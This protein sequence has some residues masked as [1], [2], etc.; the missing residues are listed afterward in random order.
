MK[1]RFAAL[2]AA[3]CAL[4]ISA[5]AQQAP[6][7]LTPGHL[8][9]DVIPSQYTITVTPDAQNL[10][11]AGAVAI[12][13]HVARPTRE[14]VL[15]ALDL[16]FDHANVDGS[17]AQQIIFDAQMQT[18]HLSFARPVAPGDHVINIAY[19][20]RI[21]RASQ[22][23]FALD[24]GANGSQERAL[25]TQFEAA[26]ARRFVPS[27]DEPLLKAVFQINVVAPENRMVVSNMPEASA[28][29]L[30]GGLKRVHF[31]PTPRMS[32]YLM[33]VGVGDFE[34]IHRDVDGVDIGVIV[35]RGDTESARFALQA[36]AQILPYYNEY[37]GVRFPLPKLD[38]VAGP[39][40]GGFGA[41][42]N[43]GAIFYFERALLVNPALS[44]ESDRQGVF[45]VIGH[46]M[47]HQWFGDLVTMAWWDD[48][49]L[50][51]GFATWMASHAENRFH[52]EWNAWL[53]AQAGRQGAM[54]QDARAS[55]H[56]I[57]QR[58]DTVDQANQAFDS[59]TYRKGAA[60]IRMIESYVGEDNFR[61]GVRQYMQAHQYGN[62]RTVDLWDAIERASSRPMRQIADDFTHQP[63]APLI[64][65]EPGPCR[66]GARELTLHQGRFGVDAASRAPQLWRAPVSAQ[67]LSG[68]AIVSGV[69]DDSRLARLIL[70]GC[71]AY[72][73][74]P[75]QAGYYR[76][77]Y[78]RAAF[79]PL[80]QAFPR[81][82]AIDQYGLLA[83]SRA[84]GETDLGAYTDAFDL[85]R[86]APIT[87]DPVV[88]ETI[89]GH[90][91][92]TNSLYRGLANAE[93]FRIFARALLRPLFARIGWDK[94]AG[95]ADNVGVLRAQLIEA[96]GELGDP[97]VI[98]EARRRFA[99]G[100]LPGAIRQATLN[101]VGANEDAAA[102]DALLQ[103]GRTETSMLGRTMY[104]TALARARDPAQ[105][106]RAL[107]HAFDPQL[108]PS[109]GPRMIQTVAFQHPD[110]AWRFAHAHQAELANRLDTL[111]QAEFLPSLTGAATDPALLAALR[112]YIDTSVPQ[113]VRPSI[114]QYYLALQHRLQVRSDKL[115]QLD[116]WLR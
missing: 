2:A 64:S 32:T 102:F 39:G 65:V 50:N 24:Y 106:Q 43:W 53:R 113:D 68:G 56:A 47:A 29:H 93:R 81:M 76:T 37:F 82:N 77:V 99:A 10:T 103:A 67:L 69:T 23:M 97:Q 98:A 107:D 51:E 58:I 111:Q 35:K 3:F 36:A 57:V 100:E 110:L 79:Q 19:R 13:V 114:E 101:V 70:H 80:L 84:L 94:Q 72:V 78:P 11:L 41:M 108:T 60:V 12:T 21:Y 88:W 28:D 38:L 8:S 73:V 59:I 49:W 85:A 86:H 30:P 95:E 116:A 52:P 4:A 115:P 26:D 9:A 14:I 74:N 71:G 15:N 66:N 104:Y 34:R 61:A 5:S 44:S 1:R 91:T 6:L 90:L 42:E 40:G 7:A 112:S 87:A 16:T 31:Q 96:L 45:G 63:G 105:A 48:I 109:L 46:E 22:G 25:Y 62:A 55:S 17:P 20:G 83:D 33:F 92:A 75:G 27:F 18:A 89:V 54:I